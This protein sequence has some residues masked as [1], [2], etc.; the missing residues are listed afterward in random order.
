MGSSVAAVNQGTLDVC[1]CRVSLVVREKY[2]LTRKFWVSKWLSFAYFLVKVE[3]HFR[4]CK[5]FTVSYIF[6]E[7]MGIGKDGCFIFELT[8]TRLVRPNDLSFLLSSPFS[9]HSVLGLSN[10]P[11]PT[12]SVLSIFLIQASVSHI[13]LDLVPPSSFRSSAFGRV[14]L[15]CSLILPFLLF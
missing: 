12:D 15:T 5:Y 14:F 2:H 10:T 1:H 6:L 9:P 7:R 3:C 11:S 8:L 13:L 4:F